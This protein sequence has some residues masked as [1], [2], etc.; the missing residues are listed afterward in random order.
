[1]GTNYYLITKSKRIAH[2]YF[3]EVETWGTYNEEY[4]LC[5]VPDFHYEIHLNKLSAGWRPLFQKHKAFQTFKDLEEFFGKHQ[6]YLKIRD[7]YYREFTWEEYKQ[8]ILDHSNAE[9][10]PVK[11]VYDEDKICGYPGK[12]Y[13]QTIRCKPEEADLWTPFS[14]IEYGE[15]EKVARERLKAWDAYVSETSMDYTM[16]PDYPIDWVSGDF[17]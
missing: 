15:T 1:M 13:L 17:S 7:E 14:H 11:W 6:K 10:R 9:R 8:E 3:A 12:K 5:D 4:E 2:K 16:D